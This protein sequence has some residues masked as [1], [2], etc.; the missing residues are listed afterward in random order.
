M[1]LADNQYGYDGIFS[2][3]N[4]DFGTIGISGKLRYN[5]L[6]IDSTSTGNGT[7]YPKGT[8]NFKDANVTGLDIIAVFG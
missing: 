8:W 4:G 6:T 7:V 3:Y 2:V 1:Y 5:F